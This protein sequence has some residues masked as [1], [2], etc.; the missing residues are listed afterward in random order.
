MANLDFDKTPLVE[1]DDSKIFGTVDTAV[2]FATTA[3]NSVSL[4]RALPALQRGPVPFYRDNVIVCDE[5]AADYLF[6][7]VSGV[8]RSCNVS[9]AGTRTI[10]AFY[11]PGDLF[12][13]TD[14]K[15]LR[16]IEAAADTAVLFIKRKGLLSLAARESRVASFLLSATTKD[17]EGA[18]EHI[19]LK[20]KSAKCRVATF[21]RGLW[22]RL[23][24][25]KYLDVP[26]S[27]QDIADYLGLT[28]ET[29]S[30]NITELERSGLIARVSGR[31]LLLRNHFALE[32][33]MH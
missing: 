22:V 23:G 14:L 11:L 17:L 28:T 25:P 26:M 7:V 9:D 30:R 18:E 31:K 3:G 33:M 2:D 16:S 24:Q 8:V 5:D 13:L 19:L 4:K 1:P 12:G 32:R 10:V 6:F 27:H 20:S 29:L 21:L 15:R